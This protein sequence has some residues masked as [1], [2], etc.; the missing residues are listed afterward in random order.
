MWK[1]VRSCYLIPH[2]SNPSNPT[3]FQKQK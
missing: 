2:P 3:S 1:D